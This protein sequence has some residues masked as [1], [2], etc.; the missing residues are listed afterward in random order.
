MV[1]L[2]E[3][4]ELS[5]TYYVCRVFFEDRKVEGGVMSMRAS[6]KSR[7]KCSKIRH[8]EMFGSTVRW[9]WIACV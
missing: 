5:L 2:G 1:N 4:P 3:I 6:A 9:I 8:L 7:L